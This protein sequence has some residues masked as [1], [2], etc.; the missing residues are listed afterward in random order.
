MGAEAMKKHLVTH[1]GRLADSYCHNPLCGIWTIA[2]H[3]TKV[4]SEATCK[5][6]L[7]VKASGDSYKPRQD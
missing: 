7:R 3:C 6:C 2:K 5:T 4:P 1:P